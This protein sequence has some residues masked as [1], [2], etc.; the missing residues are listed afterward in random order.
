MNPYELLMQRFKEMQE[1]GEPGTGAMTGAVAGNEIND[2]INF[3]KQL[4]KE[5]KADPKTL[6][7]YWSPDFIDVSKQNTPVEVAP[8]LNPKNRPYLGG[9]GFIPGAYRSEE[10][11][12]ADNEKQMME[13]KKRALQQIGD[14]YS[15]R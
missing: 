8:E 12:P 10:A 13:A 1:K 4:A 3:Y 6:Q 7:P 14:K 15:K 5:G 9:E 2:N 11:I